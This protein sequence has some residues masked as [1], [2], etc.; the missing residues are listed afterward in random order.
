MHSSE[1]IITRQ[2]QVLV[3]LTLRNNEIAEKLSLKPRTVEKCIELLLDQYGVET[4]SQVIIEALRK[5][6]IQLEEF[7]AGMRL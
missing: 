5:G 1:R 2:R 7:V 4:R 3:L 6:D